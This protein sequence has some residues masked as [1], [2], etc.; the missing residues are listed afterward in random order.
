MYT[1]NTGIYRFICFTDAGR[2]LMERLCSS[3]E[4]QSEPEEYPVK[5]YSSEF[6]ENPVKEYSSESKNSSLSDWTFDNFSKG[7]ILVFIGAIGIAVRAVAPFI[8]DK[9]TDPAV[10]VID[11]KGRF[12][13]P[14][15]SGH[16]GGAVD[17][18]RYLAGIIGAVPVLTTATDVRDEFAI[19]VFS[20]SNDMAIGDMHKAKEFTA[21]ILAGSDAQFTVTPYVKK[22][23]GMYLIPKMLVVGMGCRR[24]KSFDKLYVFLKE[25]L[26]INNY[27]IRSVKA[28]VSVDKKKDEEGLIKLSEYLNIPFVTFSPEVLMEQVGD[29]DHSDMVMKTIG[30]DNVCERAVKAYGCRQLALKKTTRDGMTIALGL[31]DV[32]IVF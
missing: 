28:L 10:I 26:D 31:T 9:T 25:I 15:L 27:D 4:H 30:A 7:N 24:G 5:E 22:D 8:K 19:D 3:I 12:V 18:A 11:E 23:G 6:N 32:D 21:R 29:F 13:I 1:A 16:L 14:V 20:S 17:A 2:E